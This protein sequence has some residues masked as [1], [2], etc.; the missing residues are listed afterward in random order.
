MGHYMI[1]AASFFASYVAI[2][3]CGSHQDRV[4]I[5]SWTSGSDEFRE[6]AVSSGNFIIEKRVWKNG[7]LVLHCK[8]GAD[9]KLHCVEY[10]SASIAS[11]EFAAPESVLISAGK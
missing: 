2:I 4:V 7:I 6:E 5:S 1:F 3:G 10:S 9:Y 8:E 11:G